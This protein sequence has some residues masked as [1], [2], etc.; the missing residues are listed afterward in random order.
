M[1]LTYRDKVMLTAVLVVLVWVAGVMLFIKPAFN[2]LSEA[3]ST[4]DS[5]VVEFNKKKDQINEDADLPQRV[6]EAFEQVSNLAS[7]FYPKLSSDEVSETIDTLLDNDKIENDSLTISSYTSVVLDVIKY[8]SQDILTDI[9]VIASGGKVE[10]D[11]QKKKNQQQNKKEDVTAVSVPCYNVSFGF[12]CKLSDLKSFLD[13]LTTYDQKS[14]VVTSCQIED[15]N[16]DEISGTMSMALMMMPEIENPIEA[17]KA[18]KADKSD[19][20]KDDKSS[21]E[22]SKAS[23]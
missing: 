6:K 23:E 21:D 12:K 8:D 9:D 19:E 1:K 16:E 17:D 13:N 2:D 5:K 15:V 7:Q 20:K 18:D 14:L 11:D 3:N 10:T 4:Y 22:S